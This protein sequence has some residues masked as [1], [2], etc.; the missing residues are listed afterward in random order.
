MTRNRSHDN[1]DRD[2]ECC[3]DERYEHSSCCDHYH[4]HKHMCLKI[5]CGFALGFGL[6][7]LIKHLRK[8]R[9]GISCCEK[10]PSERLDQPGGI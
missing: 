7:M 9:M 3:S 6:A 5:L 10:E 2:S 1:D 8:S 4:H